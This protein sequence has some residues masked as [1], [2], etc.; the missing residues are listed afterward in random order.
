MSSPVSSGKR[1][2]NFLDFLLILVVIL[3][4]ITAVF[5]FINANPNRISGGDKEITYTIKCEMLDSGIYQMLKSGDKIYDN[6]TNQLLGEVVSVAD[7][8]PITATNK[9]YPLIKLE[10]GKIN[11]YVT[12]KTQVWV[13]GGIYKI[14]NYQIAAGKVIEFHT[15]KLSVSGLC[16]AINTDNSNG[17]V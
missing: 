6:V 10:T 13:T 8:E 4:V 7:P 14:D 2:L 17:G 9:L 12:V 1:K 11:M 16:T 15:D 5:S 3:L